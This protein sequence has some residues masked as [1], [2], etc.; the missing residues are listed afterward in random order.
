MIKLRDE[1]VLVDKD[2]AE[3]FGVETR[4]VNKAVKNNP[5]NFLKSICL[6]QLKKSLKFCG[7][8]F[9]PQNLPKQEPYQKL[10]QKNADVIIINRFEN[11]QENKI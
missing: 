1:L 4:D 6:R 2:I 5:S 11:I 9:S 8:N 10:L 7:G 3:L